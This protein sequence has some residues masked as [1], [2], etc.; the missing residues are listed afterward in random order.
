MNGKRLLLDT[1][2]IVALLRGN[3][4]L[5][6]YTSAAEWIG[7]SIISQIEFV[8]FPR[9]SEPDRRLFEQFA[10]QVEVIGLN[11]ND[12]P[13]INQIVKIRQS[14]RAKLPDVIV[15]ATAASRGALLVSADRRSVSI[16]GVD[17]LSFQP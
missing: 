12:Y 8:C 13:L 16:D 7:V 1:N 6:T 3:E 14:S 2:A 11:A 15:A 10:S 9:L 17:V 4:Q 5:K